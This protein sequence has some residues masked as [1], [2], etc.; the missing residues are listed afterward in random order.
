LAQGDRLRK[1]REVGAARGEPIKEVDADE[2]SE[3]SDEDE[4]ISEELQFESPL[5]SIDP[6]VTFKH[7]LTG[8][9]GFVISSISN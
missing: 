7:A 4:S 3:S 1:E 6:Y 9:P 5:D 8:A 2:I